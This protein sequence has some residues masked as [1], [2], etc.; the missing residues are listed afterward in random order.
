MKKTVGFVVVLAILAGAGYY[1]KDR[2]L[3]STSETQASLL[4]V[5]VI[6]AEKKEF[7]PTL[8]YVAKIEAKDRV[9]VRARVTGFLTKR[10]FNEGEFVKEGQLLFLIEK[11]QFEATVRKAEANLASAIANEE[12]QAAQYKRA[13]DL[14]KTK[15]VSEARLDEQEALYSSA[16]AAVK[17]TQSELDIAKL[18]LDYTDIK[19]PISGRLG[20]AIYSV[21]SLIGPESGSLAS[22]VSTSPMYAVFSVSE[23][24]LLQIRDF[25]AAGHEEMTTGENNE[26]KISFILANGTKYDEAGSLNFIDIALDDQMNTLKLRASFPNP[27]NKL[28]AGQYGRVELQFEHPQKAVL[29]P[30]VVLQRDLAGPFV[31][32]VNDKDQLEIVRVKTGLELTSGDIIIEEGIE[33]GDRIVMNNFQRV[34][35]MPSGT[36]VH[37]VLKETEEQDTPALTE[38]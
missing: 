3:P 23:N 13:K 36:P 4:S 33:P 9:E 28:I 29:L 1:Y 27:D 12:N 17:Q 25:L 32:R 7:F 26:M 16:K 21:G 11:D 22:I 24:Q 2:F 38:E 37:P 34:M 8:S 10:L 35:M 31:Y 14:F 30:Q 15:D 20:E 6:Q 19:A 5:D 18:D